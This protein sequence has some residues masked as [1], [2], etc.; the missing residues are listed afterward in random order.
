M[1]TPSSRLLPRKSGRVRHA[2]YVRELA[3]RTTKTAPWIRTPTSRLLRSGWP[4]SRVLSHRPT[5]GPTLDV[6]ARSRPLERP[7][8]S[9]DNEGECR[10]RD[11]DF[12]SCAL[13]TELSRRWS[14][15]DPARCY[16]LDAGA[17]VSRLRAAGPTA[18]EPRVLR[19]C[20]Q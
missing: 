20:A 14:T 7:L 13:P 10:A 11:S 19:P 4:L 18:S 6:R 9:G 16:R 5:C 17:R 1:P 12:Q 15:F 2:G 3:S 8:D